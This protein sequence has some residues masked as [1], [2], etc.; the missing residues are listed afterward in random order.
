[1][2][3]PVQTC[4]YTVIPAGNHSVSAFGLKEAVQILTV[5]SSMLLVS[6]AMCG[7]DIILNRYSKQN[8]T[9][10][11]Q[12]A[13]PLSV[14]IEINF[15]TSVATVGNAID[16]LL[17]QSGY[18]YLYDNNIE[19]HNLLSLPLPRVHRSLGPVSLRTALETLAGSPWN[20]VE[21]EMNRTVKFELKEEFNH[22]ASGQNQLNTA[23]NENETNQITSSV[24]TIPISTWQL[25]P[26]HTLF[27]TFTEWTEKIGWTLEWTASH[28]YVVSHDAEFKGTFQDA[29]EKTLEFY[30]T[31]PIPLNARFYTGNSV[32]VVETSKTEN[33]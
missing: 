10:E 28:D 29:V 13:D 5:I 11:P 22:F 19:T 20:L 1:M 9:A 17:L 23:S 2:K 25:K 30:R 15:P 21:D 7:E 6:T 32:L 4:L 33:K 31:A 18:R 24:N 16:Y 3:I 26:T 27:D 14:V 8:L 12:Q